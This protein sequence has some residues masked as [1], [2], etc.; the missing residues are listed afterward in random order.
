MMNFIKALMG[1]VL[2]YCCI[3]QT[4]CICKSTMNPVDTIQN[5]VTTNEISTGPV[6]AP[7]VV[8]VSTNKIEGSSGFN[9]E[10]YIWQNWQLMGVENGK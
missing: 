8:S 4:G 5:T 6:V 2:F 7:S 10:Q 9:S 3:L 1:I